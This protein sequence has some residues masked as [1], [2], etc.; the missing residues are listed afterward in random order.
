LA[1]IRTPHIRGGNDNPSGAGP[2]VRTLS[3]G[4][5]TGTGH[6]A[7]GDAVPDLRFGHFHLIGDR[8]GTRTGTNSNVRA[9]VEVQKSGPP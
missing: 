1:R 9:S 7:D 6:F 3:F 2:Q 4:W 8:D 5:K